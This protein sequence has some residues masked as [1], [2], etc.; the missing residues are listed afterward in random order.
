MNVNKSKLMKRAWEIK[1]S[2]NTTMS[3]ALT[4]AWSESRELTADKLAEMINTEF[5]FFWT[6][7]VWEGYGKN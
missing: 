7:S 2:E 6:A 5:G 3:V 1:K 4:K